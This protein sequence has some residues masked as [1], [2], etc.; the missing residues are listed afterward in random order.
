MKRLL[1]VLGGLLLLLLIGMMLTAWWLLDSS[2]VD[3]P[4]L[5][6]RME[7]GSLEH[8][9]RRRTWH[10]YFPASMTV[11]PPLVLILHGSLGD[12][13]SM[14]EA[15]RHE[16][17]ILAE[18]EGFIA[19]Y[20]DG[21]ERHWNDCRASATYSANVLD[22]DDVGFLAALI[23]EISAEHGADPQ[24]VF[25]TGLSNG[26]QMAYRLALE[27][28]DLVAGIAAIAANLPVESNM[29]CEPSGEPVAT[30]IMNGTEDPVN[31]YDGGLVEIFGDATRGQVLS[32]AETAR[33]WAA[34]A[35]YSGHGQEEVWPDRAPDDDTTV[36]STLWSTSGKREV[37]L[38]TVIGGG[39]TIPHPRYR[40]PRSLGR[41][42]HEFDAAGFI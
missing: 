28:R 23:G 4:A 10:A 40:L 36:Q 38:I 42:S 7:H 31:P 5:A 30:L 34:L 29:D 20:P 16:F 35:G 22:I 14:L 41:T 19:V 8:D 12:G 37:I 27:T 39:H 11:R 25:A 3:A 2:E 32:A 33:Y 18:Q 1:L 17:N 13:K 6:G 24:R 9:G 21:F 15:T 26:A